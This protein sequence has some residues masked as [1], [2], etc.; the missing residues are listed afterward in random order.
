MMAA[1]RAR[2]RAVRMVENLVGWLGI[3][4]VA[5]KGTMMV[6]KKEN[7][8]VGMSVVRMVEKLAEKKVQ[9]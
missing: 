8:W 3:L 4:M 9:S 7:R 2:K 6:G 5:L 1:Q